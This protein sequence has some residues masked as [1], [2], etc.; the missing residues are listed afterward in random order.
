MDKAAARQDRL[1][2]HLFR[3]GDHGPA[4][5]GGR[6]TGIGERL[7]AWRLFGVGGPVIGPVASG[8][9]RS[10]PCWHTVAVGD[11]RGPLRR[12]RWPSRH[13]WSTRGRA[14]RPAR[15][16]RQARGCRP[17]SARR[18]ARSDS[19]AGSGSTAR[20]GWPGSR[21]T[22]PRRQRRRRASAPD[23]LPRHPPRSRLLRLPRHQTAAC[24]ED[25][26]LH[27]P[28]GT[29]VA[30]VGENGAGKTTVVKLLC[31]L[32]STDVRPDPGRRCRAGRAVPAALAGADRRRLPGLRPVRAAGPAHR[33]HRRPAPPR[34]RPGGTRR[35][36]AGPG[37]RT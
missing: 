22:P 3:D 21:T 23:R 13:G 9:G 18:S 29:T 4:R 14:P 24:C 34:R 35:R 36:W 5:Q 16:G 17:T 31:G 28:A 10:V 19:C 26:D 8:R 6:I 2:R 37:R 12:R 15:A 30:V 1:A 27:L 20:G 25:V 33:R 32:L 11:L 7:A